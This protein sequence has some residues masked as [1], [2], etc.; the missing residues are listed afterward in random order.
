MFRRSNPK[1]IAGAPCPPSEIITSL[2][3]QGEVIKLVD[4]AGDNWPITWV[5]DDLQIASYG[6]GKGF[7]RREPTLTLGFARV[8]GDPPHHRAEDLRSDADTPAGGGPAGIKSSGILMVDGKLY[9]FVRNYKPPGSDDYTNSRLASSSDGGATWTWADWYFA[10]T[11]GCPDFVQYGKNYSGARD[12]YVY[13]A[14]QA[15]D[16][17]Y[18]FSP[19]IVMFRVPKDRVADRNSYEFFAGFD[20]SGNPLW[21]RDIARRKP[22]LSDPNGCSRLSVVRNAGLGRYI[23]TKSHLPVGS[24]PTPY[25]PAMGVFDAAEPWGPW[26]AVY[27]DDHW[28]GDFRTYHHKF[29][30]KWMS[31]DGKTMWLLFSGLDKTMP[32]YSFCL[33]KASL[34]VAD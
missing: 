27:Y 32:Y 29:P 33:L 13:V 4:G 18:E 14:S 28:S 26:T 17:A 5:D 31:R 16:S 2:E 19:D 24:R 23:M 11:F 7:S 25:T 1:L 10:D 12:D 30:A 15:N 9:L 21:S 22:I 3:W 20:V 6:D 34:E 8:Y